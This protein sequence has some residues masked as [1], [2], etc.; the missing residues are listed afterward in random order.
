MKILVCPDSFKESLSASSVA[1]TVKAAFE[2][3][4]KQKNISVA[5]SSL[6][7]ADGGEGSV[8]AIY[9]AVGGELIRINVTGPYGESV[10]ATYL[11]HG[12]DAYIEMAEASGLALTSRRECRYATTYG[13]GEMIS[14][15]MNRG[16]EKLVVFVGGSATCDGGIGMAEALGYGFYSETGEKL[17]PIGDSLEKIAHITMPSEDALCKVQI[18]CATDVTNPLYGEQ[19]AAYVFAPQKG[20]EEKDVCE[21]DRGLRHLAALIEK[22]MKKH[23]SDLPGAGAAGGLG[24]GLFAFCSAR[25]CGGFSLIAELL[26]LKAR[27]NESDLVIT[28]EGCTDRQSI[29][30]KAVGKIAEICK[31]NATRLAVISGMLKDKEILSSLDGI[32]MYECVKYAKSAGDS[33]IDPIPYLTLAAKEAA[34]ELL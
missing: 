13:T 6:P 30:G 11:M 23:V 33:Q 7:I 34:N 25:M 20:A 31:A 4:A 32:S 26:S 19:G 3:V 1:D 22:E 5:V 24:G 17:S 28:G 21:L 12:K 16:A 2:D 8:R 10:F 15:A 18:I 14:D 29:M 9:E 27:I